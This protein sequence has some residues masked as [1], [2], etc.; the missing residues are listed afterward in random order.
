MGAQSAITPLHYDKG[1]NLLHQV[2]G[3][4]TVFDKLS[5]CV[6]QP[7]GNYVSSSFLLMS[8]L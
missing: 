2:S 1:E 3:S 6:R 4:K 7:G 8:S 5:P